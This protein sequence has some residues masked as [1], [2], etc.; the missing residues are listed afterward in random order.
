[1]PNLLMNNSAGTE[2]TTHRIP[3]LRRLGASSLRSQ[4]AKGSRRAK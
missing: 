1:M 3:L 4:S 2:I